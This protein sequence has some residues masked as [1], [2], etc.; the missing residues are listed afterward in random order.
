M[1]ESHIFPWTGHCPG[2][3]GPISGIELGHRYQRGRRGLMGRVNFELDPEGQVDCGPVEGAEGSGRGGDRTVR[4][5]EAQG[6]LVWGGLGPSQRQKEKLRAETPWNRGLSRKGHPPTPEILPGD[7][8]AGP[9]R[10]G[11]V[12]WPWATR[13][14]VLQ[15]CSGPTRSGTVAPV[16]AKPQSQPAV[17]PVIASEC[18]LPL[19][20]VQ[21]R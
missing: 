19:G 14:L 2:D 4:R 1:Q 9:H 10:A 12:C 20:A 6:A 17:S 15:A 7:T 21:T 8:L 3:R 11:T 5:W 13:L 16:T 18:P